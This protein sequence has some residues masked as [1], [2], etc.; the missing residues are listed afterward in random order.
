MGRLRW[1]GVSSTDLHPWLAFDPEQARRVVTRFFDEYLDSAGAKGV[2]VGISGG[3]DS[4]MTAALA[5]EAL[6]PEAV[7]AVFLPGPTSSPEDRRVAQTVTDHLGLGLDEVAIGPA[8][9]AL[10]PE[11]G[12][13]AGTMITANLQARLRMTVSYARAQAT[14]RLV[15]GTGNKSEL[16]VGYFT[17]HGD[18]GVDLLPLGDL[19]KTQLRVL[20]GEMALPEAVVTRPPTAGLWEGQTDEDELGLPYNALDVILAGIERQQDD[21]AIAEAAGVDPEEV[22]RIQAMVRTSW[23]KR[24]PPPVPKLGWRTPLVD[25]RESTM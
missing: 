18:G 10:I 14:S 6:G 15:A 21:P 19:Y 3:L 5:T 16:M 22:A 8:A 25:W 23:H 17:K 11:L 1:P 13:E 2:V 20:A 24:N 7:D 4:A 9:E 12:V